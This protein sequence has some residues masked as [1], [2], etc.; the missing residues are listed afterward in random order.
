MQEATAHTYRDVD[1]LDPEGVTDQIVRQH[2]RALEAC[3]CPAGPVRVGNIQL[4]DGDGVD[5]VGRLG[6]GALD[7]QLVLVGQD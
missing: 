4:G 3:V 2:G 1:Q 6:N 7:R 5:L